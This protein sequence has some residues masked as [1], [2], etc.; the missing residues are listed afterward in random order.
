VNSIVRVIPVIDLQ[1]G[2]VV[3][4]VGGRRHEYRLL[5]TVLT[6]DVTP[7]GVARALAENFP[8]AEV[9]VAD[10]DA[11]AGRE[12]NWKAYQAI[13]RSG[14]QLWI[15]AG[16]ADETRATDLATFDGAP[17]GAILVGLES[18]ESP[19]ALARIV[20][21]PVFQT[22]TRGRVAFSL[23]LREGKPLTRIAAW[24][25]WS[26]LQV[27]EFAVLSGVTQMIVLDLTHVGESRGVGGLE[28]CRRIHE[29]FPAVEL[30]G[31]GGVRTREDAEQL[32]GVGCQAVLLASALHAGLFTADDVARL[33]TR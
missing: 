1:G 4:G 9:Y 22:A 23:D 26:P 3:R 18:L 15:D 20:A 29:Q 25:D 32:A 16:A 14:L 13:G 12:P 8:V 6:R 27:A 30:I 19:D 31:G 10:L 17:V 5:E 24:Q 11:I 33:G 21:A 28:A 7:R 2:E